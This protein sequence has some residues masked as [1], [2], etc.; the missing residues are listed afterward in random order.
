VARA[1]PALR[2]PERL[3]AIKQNKTLA[4][5]EEAPACAGASRQHSSKLYFF[6]RRFAFFGAFAFAFFA[7][8]AISALRDGLANQDSTG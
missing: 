8:F 4:Q 5:N 1:I 2:R 6:F 3:S 7:F